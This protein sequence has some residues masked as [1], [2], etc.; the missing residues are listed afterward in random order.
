MRNLE[1]GTAVGEALSFLLS[2]IAEQSRK[3]AVPLTETELKQLSFSEETASA[4]EIAGAEEFDA[5]NDTD[6]F[7]EKIAQLLRHAF[8]H[9]VQNG[10]GAIWQKHLAALREHDIYVL[11]MVDQAGISRSTAK[12]PV[13]AFFPR[14]PRNLIESLPQAVAGLVTVCGFIYFL[15]LMR[16]G[17]RG[18]PLFGDLPR[19]LIP[20]ESVQSAF[21]VIWIGSMLWLWL[22][23]KPFR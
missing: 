10:K 15:I 14:S 12:V 6:Q 20:S 16:Q 19:K 21:F 2:R 5:A 3:D 13:A 11:V 4:D 23:T 7:E 22:R 17:R 9:D 1:T 8:D 18:P